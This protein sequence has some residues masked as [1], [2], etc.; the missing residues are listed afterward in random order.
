MY[1]CIALSSVP[2]QHVFFFPLDDFA[3]HNRFDV[4]RLCQCRGLGPTQ[5]RN[6]ESY[7]S[8]SNDPGYF[9]WR[10]TVR[11]DW[12]PLLSPLWESFCA[13]SGFIWADWCR[14]ILCFHLN[15]LFSLCSFASSLPAAFLTSFFCLSLPSFSACLRWF[16]YFC[17]ITWILSGFEAAANQRFIVSVT[18]V[19]FVEKSDHSEVHF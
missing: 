14:P 18:S 7:A 1:L 17:L 19:N 5:R 6:I 3:V 15:L 9:L 12:S 2:C 11:W 8:Q 13:A 4:S 16:E 10:G